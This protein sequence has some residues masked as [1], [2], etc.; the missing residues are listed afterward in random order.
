MNNLKDIN[1]NLTRKK[2]KQDNYQLG[3]NQFLLF[4]GFFYGV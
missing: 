3:Y 2:G 4:G 1:Y